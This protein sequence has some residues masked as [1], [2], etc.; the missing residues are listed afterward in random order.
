MFTSLF[1]DRKPVV[2]VIHVGALP[3]T[4][5]SARTVAEITEAAVREAAAYRSAGVDALMVENMHDV[6]YMRGGV[7]PE[8]VAAMAVVGRAGKEGAGLPAGVQIL[9]GAKAEER[10]GGR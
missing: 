5:A 8:I 4:P 7:G 10:A 2:G 3:G 6:P 9:A 1:G